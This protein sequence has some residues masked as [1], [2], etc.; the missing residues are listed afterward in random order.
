MTL[1]Y[2]FSDGLEI[3]TFLQGLK[4]SALAA[5]IGLIQTVEDRADIHILAS[6]DPK[7]PA[8]GLRIA[9]GEGWGPDLKLMRAIDVYLNLE[10]FDQTHAEI[11]LSWI[12]QRQEMSRLNSLRHELGNLVVILLGRIM[13]MKS[14]NISNHVDSLQLLHKR[15][16]K[17]YEELESLAVPRS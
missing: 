17:L 1:T 11:L 2:D 16:H 6:T 14:D 5:G 8:T 7:A 4:A 9:V 3:E 12:K 13:Q 15:M 10:S